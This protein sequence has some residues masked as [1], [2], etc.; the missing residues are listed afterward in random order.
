VNF[1]F[2]QK[3][4]NHPARRTRVGRFH[5][6]PRIAHSPPW[7]TCTHLARDGRVSV[8]HLLC[9]QCFLVLELSAGIQS[10][11]VTECMSQIGTV[12]TAPLLSFSMS[13][14]SL[15]ARSGPVRQAIGAQNA[16][17][18]RPR[19]KHTAQFLTGRKTRSSK[20]QRGNAPRTRRPGDKSPRASYSK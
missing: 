5:R 19:L 18:D 6:F 9:N 1:V 3:K 16:S 11:E 14:S 15:V 2:F 20:C 7:G 17:E 12:P 13:N 8:R 10:L 4:A